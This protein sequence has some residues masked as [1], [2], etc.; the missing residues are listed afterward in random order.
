MAAPTLNVEE[1]QYRDDG[2]PLN[3]TAAIPF[4]DVISVKGLDAAEV[5]ETVK[6]HEGTDGGFVDATNETLRTVVLE[7]EAYTDPAAFETYMESLKANFEPSAISLPFYI[8]TDA[9]MRVVYGKSTGVKYTKTNSRSYGRQPFNVTVLCED[10][11]VYIAGFASVEINAGG[12]IGGRGYNK[13]YP[14]GYGP[15]VKPSS[16]SLVLAGSRSVPGTYTLYG[17][18]ITPTIINDTYGLQW[19]YN[20]ALSADDYLT[21]NPRLKTV[22]LNGGPS[23]R[24]SMTGKWWSLRVG[25]NDFRLQATGVVEGKTKL[26]ITTEPARR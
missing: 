21:I 18:A 26:V 17:P 22:R 11:R 2:I 8:M 25:T 4:V 16:G 3:T 7:C 13:G 1:Y 15:V 14:F 20:L 12:V 5:R 19:T 10:P 23:R 6:D 9:G 24:S